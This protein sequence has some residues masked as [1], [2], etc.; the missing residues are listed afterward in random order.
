[1]AQQD[2][3]APA[4]YL[5]FEVVLHPYLKGGGPSLPMDLRPPAISPAHSCVHT[6]LVSALL[7]GTQH[8]VHEYSY[9]SLACLE[10]KRK[11]KI[12]QIT[13][14]SYPGVLYSFWLVLQML[15]LQTAAATVKNP[16]SSHWKSHQQWTFY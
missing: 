16:N 6:V 9:V 7:A 5:N 8:Q 11:Q 3:C 4:G 14:F 15:E 1:M 13:T 10:I 2:I 12:D